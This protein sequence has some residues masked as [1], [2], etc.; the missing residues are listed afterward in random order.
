MVPLDAAPNPGRR[1]PSP[2]HSNIPANAG[3]GGNLLLDPATKDFDASEWEVG[4]LSRD[5]FSVTICF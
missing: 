4:G 3:P 5:C 2:F 1:Q